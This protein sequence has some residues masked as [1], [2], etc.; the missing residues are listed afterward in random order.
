VI[1]AGSGHP[2]VFGGPGD[3]LLVGGTSAI[4]VGGDGWDQCAGTAL[5][6]DCER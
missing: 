5:L 2:R 3:D 4:L 1:L 6:Q